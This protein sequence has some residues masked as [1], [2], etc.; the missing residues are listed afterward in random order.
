MKKTSIGLIALIVAGHL[1]QAF[2]STNASNSATVSALKTH[3]SKKLDQLKTEFKTARDLETQQ[4]V[5]NRYLAYAHAEIYRQTGGTGLTYETLLAA[6]NAA[7][8]LSNSGST[9]TALK[10]IEIVFGNFA[11]ILK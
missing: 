9:T 5:L 10:S 1:S 3:Y 11:R 2:A 8:L 7:Q 6:K 4:Q